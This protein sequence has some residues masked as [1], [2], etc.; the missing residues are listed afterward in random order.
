[1]EYLTV[2]DVI[3]CCRQGIAAFGGKY[4]LVDRSK[5]ESAVHQPQ[6]GWGNQRAFPTI[7]DASAAYL[8]YICNAHAF[9]DGNKRAAMISAELFLQRN[10]SEFG[11]P[12]EEMEA[13]TLGVAMGKLKIADLVQVL[14]IEQ[15]DKANY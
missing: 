13:I 10:G 4:A 15:T 1:L 7:L 14:R 12:D 6:C 9:L 3:E 11:N 5:L 8:F 2:E